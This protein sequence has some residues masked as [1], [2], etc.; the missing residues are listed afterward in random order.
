MLMSFV[1]CCWGKVCKTEGQRREEM[2]S[3]N[4]VQN[5]FSDECKMI[6]IYI[7]IYNKSLLLILISLSKSWQGISG[8]CH[9]LHVNIDY[10]VQCKLHVSH[11]PISFRRKWMVSIHIL[12][13]CMTAFNH[14]T[15]KAAAKYVN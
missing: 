12:V 7:Y 13:V 1:L 5:M 4:A 2:H 3:T 9:C 11:W 14:Y 8:N 10:S 15:V 6:Y